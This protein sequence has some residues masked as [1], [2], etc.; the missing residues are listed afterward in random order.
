MPSLKALLFLSLLLLALTLGLAFCHVMEIS[1]K[2]RLDGPDWLRVQQNLYVAFGP[3][4]GAGIEVVAIA[5]TWFTAISTRGRRPAAFGWTVA[6][7][8]AVTA[9]LALG[10]SSWRPSARRWT[11][12]PRPPCRRTGPPGACGGRSATPCTRSAWPSG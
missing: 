9:G 1:G 3:P 12:G 8:V 11:P 5:L 7:G 2:F 4:V 6:S 10:G